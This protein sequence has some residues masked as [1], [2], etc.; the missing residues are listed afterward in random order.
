MLETAIA[1]VHCTYDVYA[2]WY[3]SI[4]EL[5]VLM[6]MKKRRRLCSEDKL[7]DIDKMT[8][9]TP[10]GTF[11]QSALKHTPNDISEREE[12][13]DQRS[14]PRRGSSS[15]KKQLLGM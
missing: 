9:S 12:R 10:L 14:M 6:R 13:G 4:P 11:V 7:E 8:G 1:H 5:K 3:N 15:R 2:I